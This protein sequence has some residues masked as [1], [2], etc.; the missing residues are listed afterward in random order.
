VGDGLAERA[1][2]GALD[3]EVDPLMVVG[4]VGEFLDLILRDRQVRAVPEV[5]ADVVL[6]VCDARNGCRHDASVPD[7]RVAPEMSA[8]P[9]ARVFAALVVEQQRDERDVE[10]DGQVAQ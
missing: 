1:A 5:L 7:G 6:D 4:R 10:D 3:V 9:D 8:K 2:L